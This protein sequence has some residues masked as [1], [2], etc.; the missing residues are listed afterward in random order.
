MSIIRF[1]LVLVGVAFVSMVYGQSYIIDKV[2]A[3][4]GSENILLS[5]LEGDFSYRKSVEPTIDESA[6]CFILEE[7]IAQKVIVY[8]ARLDSVLVTDEEIE[9]RLNYRFDAVLAQMNGD[10]QFF[11]EYYG[12]TIAEMK[13]RFR[14]DQEQQILAERMQS[15]ILN[16]VSITPKEVKAYYESI[17][18]DSIP[19]LNAEVELAEIV[20]KPVVNKEERQKA[21]LKIEDL[22]NRIVEGGESFTDLAIKHS[23][24]FGSGQ[25]GGDLGFAKRGTFVPEFEAAV[26][27]L[28]PN[29]ISDIIETEFGFHIIQLIERRGNSVRA[30]HILIR[31]EILQSDI[32][33]A[34]NKLDSIRTLILADSMSFEFAVKKF[35]L[36]ET[37][38][39]SNNGRVKN[40]KTGNNFFEAADLDPDTY[41]AIDDMDIGGIT[42]PLEMPISGN[43][44]YFRIVKLQALT[45]PHKANLSQD[46]DKITLAA[47]EDKKA[48]YFSEWIQGKMKDIY[49]EIDPIIG[50]CDNLSVFTNK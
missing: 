19:Y 50:Q 2:I 3:K 32:D 4:V 13:D 36:K 26:F 41:F 25:K 14:D 6:K 39:Y 24:D 27:T 23:M 38:S 7:I 49:V 30:R 28:K 43:D 16:E 44:K 29:E 42:E 31:P 33:L 5:D 34:I 8:S 47:K 10:E 15:Q 18:V 37:P 46:Y 22:R 1:S 20:I 11:Q 40:P 35:G 48:E 17:P 45:K 9:A 12:A 21:F